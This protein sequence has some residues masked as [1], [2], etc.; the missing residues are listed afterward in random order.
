MGDGEYG[1]SFEEVEETIK[2]Q[3]VCDGVSS[4]TVAEMAWNITYRLEAS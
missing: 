3:A 4:L 1:G 2:G